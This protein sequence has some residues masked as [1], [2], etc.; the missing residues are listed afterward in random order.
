MKPTPPGDAESERT[1]A[2]AIAAIYHGLS[3]AGVNPPRVFNLDHVIET[4]E[5]FRNFMFG[6]K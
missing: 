1:I 2:L 5:E 3:N 6:P 4:A